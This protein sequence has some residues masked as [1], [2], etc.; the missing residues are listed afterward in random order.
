MLKYQRIYENSNTT[1]FTFRVNSSSEIFR[2]LSHK[3]EQETPLAHLFV[4]ER[5]TKETLISKKTFYD[6]NFN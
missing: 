5:C 3:R 6:A 2:K 4:G 1:V